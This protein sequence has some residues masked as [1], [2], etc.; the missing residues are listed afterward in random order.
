MEI[1][2]FLINNLLLGGVGGTLF[3]VIG[4]LLAKFIW[5]RYSSRLSFAVEE[6]LNL[7]SQW[8]ALC[9]SQRDLFKKLRSRWQS[10]RDVWEKEIADKDAMIAKLSAKPGA[11][12]G[13]S[14]ALA[15]LSA[16]EMQRI[17]ELEAILK[18]RD[19]EILALKR[20]EEAAT[21]KVSLAATG[22][23]SEAES[24][25]KVQIQD[26]EQDL[27]DTHDEL[28]DLREG[29]R[30]Q[31]DLIESLEARLINGPASPDDSARAESE[32]ARLKEDSA[33]SGAVSAKEDQLNAIAKQRG[34]ELQQA[35][36]LQLSLLGEVNRERKLRA[37]LEAN[38]SSEELKAELMELKLE[39]EAR[40][41][42]IEDLKTTLDDSRATLADNESKLEEVANIERRKASIQAELNDACHEMYDV[43]SALNERLD[44]ISI[45]ESLVEELEPL[46]D[47]TV[48]L[49]SDVDDTRHELSDVR[50]A[51]NESISVRDK[52]Q[53]QM[54]E[55]EAIIED[56]TSEVND[57]SA[58]VRQQRD[59]IRTLK[60]TLA[61]QEG[62]LEA[63]NEESSGIHARIASKETLIAEQQLRVTDLESALTKRYKEINEVRISSGDHERAAM[64]HESRADKLQAE[65][66][67]RA[68][69]FEESDH[70]VSTAEEALREANEKISDLTARLEESESSLTVLKSEISDVSTAKEDNIR[71]LEKARNRIEVLEEAAREREEQLS[72]LEFE[73]QKK[74]TEANS[75]DSNIARL[76]SELEDAR[77]EKQFSVS[78]VQELEDALK[79]SDQATLALSAE[80]EK[81]DAELSSFQA[82][83][84]DLQEKLTRF[85]EESASA[86]TRI[87]EL[88]GELESTQSQLLS[89]EARLAESPDK[90]RVSELQAEIDKNRRDLEHYNSQRSQSVEEIEKLRTK[91]AGRGDTIRE[92]KGQISDIMMQR[93]TRDD[94]IVLLKDKLRA[95]ESELKAADA[96]SKQ[97]LN[98]SLQG[99]SETALDIEAAIKETLDEEEASHVE[100]LSLDDLDDEKQGH[101]SPSENEQEAEDSSADEARGDDEDSVVYFEEGNAALTDAGLAKIDQC[102]RLSRR[103]RGKL[104]ISV[105]GFAGPEGT[106]DFTESLSARRADAVR[107]RLLERGVAQSLISVRSAGQDRRFTDWK[108]RRVE[109]VL[110]PR[111][112]AEVVN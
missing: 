33:H 79:E 83:V 15:S 37:E 80:V 30:K 57:L 93:A 14:N 112:V 32:L 75:L 70:R 108:A 99:Q 105:I 86:A 82:E 48:R 100:G 42:Q 72:S 60:N 23:S 88:E 51:Y 74:N 6:N 46:A 50:L 25:H 96:S 31:S 39:L 1:P 38:D 18:E 17:K 106:S 68:Q 97:V 87:T 8:S 29:Y 104:G 81:K 34:R 103:S 27:I 19:A 66:D 7:A 69:S 91:V 11:S 10:D 13:S 110:A 4:L 109:L 62:E 71:E 53:A 55:L 61:E 92:L 21:K 22:I 89:T 26:L 2:T 67:R 3:T 76:S 47:E 107:E 98:A 77:N 45:L 16:A 56:R 85:E 12:G 40:D 24:H 36:A 65:L 41:T 73:F 52:L 78:A 44:E 20:S 58:E 49:Y 9:T 111:A 43:R 101:H 54:E 102:A 35:K 90:E 5:G 63:L 28:H 64:Y 59:T 94:E 95:I 84:S